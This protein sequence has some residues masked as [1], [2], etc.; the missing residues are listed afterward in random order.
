M[1]VKTITGSALL[2]AIALLSQGFLRM[3]IPVHGLVQFLVG[4]IVGACT[5]LATW[6]Y[7]LWSG[8]V[9]ACV[10]PL[11]AFVQGM[12]T[13]PVFVPVVAVGSMA[14]AVTV[15][16]LGQKR[17]WVTA[18]SGA[19]V[20]SIVLYGLFLELFQLMPGIPEAMQKGILFS[21]GWPQLITGTCGI[22]L[23]AFI[24]KRGGIKL[25]KQD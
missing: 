22:F 6:R 4:S 1:S 10:T 7:G 9:V 19:I 8:F 20:K 25:Q 14:Y 5:A 17:I 16:M 11:M 15:K 23:A 18:I 12:L 21:M 3:I 24:A 13:I 2:L